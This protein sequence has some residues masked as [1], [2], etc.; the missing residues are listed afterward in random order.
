MKKII[1]FAALLAAFSMLSGRAFAQS[2][3]TSSGNMTVTAT[4]NS[5]IQMVFDSVSGKVALSAEGTN[6]P[7]L[8]LGSVTAYETLPGTMSRTVNGTTNYTIT[9]GF[10][11]K[12]TQANSDSSNYTLTAQ[13]ASADSTNSWAI[14]GGSALS[15]ASATTVTAI[16]T[17]GSDNDHTVSLTIPFAT[18]DSAPISEQINFVA[19]SN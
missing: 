15:D 18:A 13:L 5:S 9:T 17:Y 6:N 2:G 10:A 14:D 16:G 12:V 4:V 8:A 3:D 1:T 19:T 11:V 7:T